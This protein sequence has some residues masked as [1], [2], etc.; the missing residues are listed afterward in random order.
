MCSTYASMRFRATVQRQS[1][2]TRV[3]T[4][5]MSPSI[6]AN[7]TGT[8]GHVPEIWPCLC[9]VAERRPSV[10]QREH[11]QWSESP[12][13]RPVRGSWWHS[14]PRPRRR[15][16]RPPFGTHAECASVCRDWWRWPGAA[17]IDGGGGIRP[18]HRS[19]RHPLV[20]GRRCH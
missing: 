20:P 6:V 11:V 18:V 4:I 15:C 13:H 10:G 3:N 9:N 1:C 2:Q 12:P 17:P 7:A 8:G 14:H 16:R 5:A 19:Q